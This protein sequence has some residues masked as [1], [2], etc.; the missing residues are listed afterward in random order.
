MG[1]KRMYRSLLAI[2]LAGVFLICL[3]ASAA[4]IR[5]DWSREAS[6][7]S[8][9]TY[10]WIPS[11]AT[12]HPFYRQYVDEYVNYALTHKKHLREVSESQN[13]DLLVTYQLST[14]DVIDTQTYG[15]GPGW[16][17]W[18]W[19]GWGWGGWGW[20]W[21]GPSYYQTQQ[22]PR[23]MGVLTL[24]LIDAK[25]KKI[26]W[27]GQAI[28]ENMMKSG[29]AEEKQV[30]DSIYDMLKRYPPGKNKY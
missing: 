16:S 14:K 28:Q 5:V 20:G 15:Y 17:G 24:N 25:T 1:T 10:Q 2:S 4:D 13:P 18:G 6:F 21:G 12:N 19:G 9:H 22:I 30:A 7:D 23:V 11:K 8:Y 26:V 3:S 27:Q 29:N